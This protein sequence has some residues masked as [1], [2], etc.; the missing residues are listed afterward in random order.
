MEQLAHAAAEESEDCLPLGRLPVK[1]EMI[2]FGDTSDCDSNRNTEQMS[3]RDKFS[4]AMEINEAYQVLEQMRRLNFEVMCQD[5]SFPPNEI[6]FDT[7]SQCLLEGAHVKQQDSLS[8]K[9]SFYMRPR[10]EN[11]P[12]NMP[13][14]K[15]FVAYR[16]QQRKPKRCLGCGSPCCTL[17]SSAEFREEGIT[18]CHECEEVSSLNV[19]LDCLTMNIGEEN[20]SIEIQAYVEKLINLYDRVLLLLRFSEQY[21]D[22]MTVALEH[23]KSRNNKINVGG[24]SVGIVSGILGV[25]AAATIVTPAGVPLLVASLMLGTGATA[26][27]TGTEV[28]EKYFS[29]PNQFANRVIALNGVALSI[30][31][32]VGVLR[33]VIQRDYLQMHEE[34]DGSCS[35]P[36]PLPRALLESRTLAGVT[37][38]RLVAGS[39]ELVLPEG[40]AMARGARQFS[41]AGTGALRSLRFARFAGGALAAAT[42]VLEARSLGTTVKAIREGSPCEKAEA[43]KKIKEEIPSL[44]DT[45][46][47]DQECESYLLYIK[48]RGFRKDELTRLIYQV[49]RQEFSAAEESGVKEKNEKMMDLS[50][51]LFSVK[52][53]KKLQD[54][55][56]S[57]QSDKE[58]AG[59]FE[60]NLP[61]LT[62]NETEKGFTSL[63]TTFGGTFISK[64]RDLSNKQK[65][66]E[67]DN[68]EETMNIGHRFREWT[69]S[70]TDSATGADSRITSLSECFRN[71]P[72]LFGSKSVALPDSEESEIKLADECPER[73]SLNELWRNRPRV[74]GTK[75][76]ESAKNILK[77]S[78]H[79]NAPKSPKLTNSPRVTTAAASEAKLDLAHSK[80]NSLEKVQA[81]DSE[82]STAKKLVSSPTDSPATRISSDEKQNIAK[83]RIN[84]TAGTAPGI[85]QGV[86]VGDAK[87][88]A[89]TLVDATTE[90]ADADA[91]SSSA[92]VQ[93]GDTLAKPT[94]PE[95]VQTELNNSGSDITASIAPAILQDFQVDD[96][97]NTEKHAD[98]ITKSAAGERSS[99]K[100]VDARLEKQVEHVAQIDDVQGF[101]K[102]YQNKEKLAPGKEMEQQSEEMTEAV[103]GPQIPNTGSIEGDDSASHGS[104]DVV[105]E[106]YLAK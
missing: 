38:G 75:A 100:V 64:F 35:S 1:E 95:E 55:L 91:D 51:R 62:G 12:N 56:L 5:A 74:F 57:P 72:R 89:G 45:S 14:L 48:D 6:D 84:V 27:Q 58:S 97:N 93:A 94:T 21:L 26:A 17:H 103:K 40:V 32:I 43:L 16:E 106:E 63:N 50:S 68:A 29:E 47:L 46:E 10:A 7:C 81:E 28:K 101:G 39:A 105:E 33:G 23:T 13:R 70:E 61:Q 71:R 3:E 78:S 67:D 60:E 20:A 34:T 79:A 65:S 37:A 11:V 83:T 25:A 88:I 9:A 24:S 31:S 98:A 96:S 77:P 18:L 92:E 15:K 19:F 86:Q 66:A 99:A 36:A 54:K 30:L 90:S 85:L 104:W 80:S 22:Q 2:E 41:R 44:A 42:V 82:M 8:R 49:T 102:F 73:P 4:R 76:N 87:N 52:L 53:V 59:D 69:V